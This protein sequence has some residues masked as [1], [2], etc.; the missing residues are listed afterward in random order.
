MPNAELAPEMG[1]AEQLPARAR[2]GGGSAGAALK[3]S[4]S[5]RTCEAGHTLL[6]LCSHA[7]AGT[8]PRLHRWCNHKQAGDALAPNFKC[9]A[10]PK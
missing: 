3:P 2:V 6:G 1:R 10:R 7:D 9:C 8:L 5:W 4:S